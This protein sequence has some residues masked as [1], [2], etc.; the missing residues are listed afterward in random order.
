MFMSCLRH[1]AYLVLSLSSKTCLLILVLFVSPYPVFRFSLFNML[2][3]FTRNAHF[4]PTP[5]TPY[6]FVACFERAKTLFSPRR[7][8]HFQTWRSRLHERVIFSCKTLIQ[9]KR[10]SPVDGMHILHV[11]DLFFFLTNASWSLLNTT[12][13]HLSR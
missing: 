11:N 5:Q 12:C 2:V 9:P 1:H 4:G 13:R 3:S 7:R 8:A 10:H 6:E